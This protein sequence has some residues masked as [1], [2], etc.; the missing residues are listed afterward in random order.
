MGMVEADP[1]LLVAVIG[2]FV[3]S[4]VKIEINLIDSLKF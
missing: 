1:V 2:W 3:N 4:F